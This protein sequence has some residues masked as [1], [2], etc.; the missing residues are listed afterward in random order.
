MLGM[1][2][3]CDRLGRN[4]R[5]RRPGILDAARLSEA[6]VT[7]NGAIVKSQTNSENSIIE[8]GDFCPLVKLLLC[9]SES[10][11]SIANVYC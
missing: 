1:S 5:G 8:Q 9:A 6:W 4:C 7:H 11:S 10:Y 3:D 2:Y